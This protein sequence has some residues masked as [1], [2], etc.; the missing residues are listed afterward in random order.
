[1]K[2]NRLGTVWII[3]AINLLKNILKKP[4]NK[5]IL[6]QIGN[7]H[8]NHISVNMAVIESIYKLFRNGIKN[9]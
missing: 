8:K 3:I 6:Y 1:M 5:I 4:I 9:S 2:L 7:L